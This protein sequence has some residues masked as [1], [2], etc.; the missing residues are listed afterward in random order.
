ME[1]TF[2][3]N[4]LEAV[5][6]NSEFKASLVER[7]LR[8]PELQKTK[9]INPAAQDSQAVGLT[10]MKH[11]ICFDYNLASSLYFLFAMV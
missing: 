7:V 1:H 3:P 4:I 6:E 10:D 5:A 2:N 8:E 11:H 9:T